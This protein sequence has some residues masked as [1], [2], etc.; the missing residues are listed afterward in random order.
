[1]THFHQG[2]GEMLTTIFDLTLNPPSSIRPEVIVVRRR[3]RPTWSTPNLASWTLTITPRP[4]NM[5]L[6]CLNTLLAD[7]VRAN[8]RPTVQGTP[9]RVLREEPRSVPVWPVLERTVVLM[10]ALGAGFNVDLAPGPL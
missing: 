9:R 8:K 7:P 6:K 10:E 2:K 1:M 5:P 4:R 3:E